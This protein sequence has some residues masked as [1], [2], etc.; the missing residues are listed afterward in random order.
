MVLI[1]QIMSHA[2]T[3]QRLLAWQRS[4]AAPRTDALSPLDMQV[5][6]SMAK[7]C[8]LLAVD[9]P[10]R[11]V[12]KIKPPLCFSTADADQLLSKLAEVSHG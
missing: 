5:Q 11:N 8:V 2:M 9:G 4:A 3:W 12:V 6:N 7:R 10:L 1:L